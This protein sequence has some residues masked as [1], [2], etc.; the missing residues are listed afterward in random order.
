M[1]SFTGTLDPVPVQ[2][3]ERGTQTLTLLFV[4]RAFSSGCTA[5]TGI[6][7]ISNGIPVFQKPEAQNAGKTLIAM[8]A[9]L[10][11]MFLGFSFLA[12]SLAVIPTEDQTVV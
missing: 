9:L 7:A 2:E 8:T 6:E 12:R 1:R 10:A 5:L 11:T 3:V 4:L